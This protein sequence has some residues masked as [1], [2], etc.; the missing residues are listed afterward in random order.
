[1][2]TEQIQKIV[3]EAPMGARMT[4]GFGY[5]KCD[6]RLEKHSISDLKEI[7]ALRT[8]RDE[9]EALLTELQVNYEAEKRRADELAAITMPCYKS[10]RRWFYCKKMVSTMNDVKS[11]MKFGRRFWKT[12]QKDC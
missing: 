3:E 5:F 4:D 9:Q 12:N 6:P 10:L 2:K 1:M 7:L 11:G 8:E